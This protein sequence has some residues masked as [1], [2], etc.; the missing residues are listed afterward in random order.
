M[1]QAAPPYSRFRRMARRGGDRAAGAGMKMVAE[2]HL[3]RE[4]IGA[5]RPKKMPTG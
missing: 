2:D 1:A 3:F 4:G 5:A